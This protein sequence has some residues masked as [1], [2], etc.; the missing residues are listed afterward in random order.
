LRESSISV[1]DLRHNFAVFLLPLLA[2]C[3]APSGPIGQPTA[4]AP[5]APAELAE[6][7]FSVGLNRIAEVYVRPVAVGEL[8]VNGLGN[9]KALDKRLAVAR[10]G[11]RV[12]FSADGAELADIAAPATDDPR[13]WASFA[14]AAVSRLRQASPD[15]AKASDDDI[16]QT[17][18]DGVTA[19]L[20]DYSRYAAPSRAA[21]ERADREGYGGIG[22]QIEQKDGRVVIVKVNGD[23]PAERAGLKSGETLFRIDGRPTAEMDQTAV[24]NALRGDPN[25]VVVLAVGP[26]EA[27]M[28]DVEVRREKVVPNTVEATAEGPAG[29][30]KLDRFNVTSTHKMRSAVAKLKQ[31][32]GRNLKGFVLDLRGNP[33]GLLDQAVAISDLFVAGGKIVLTKGRHPDSVNAYDADSE[34]I[35]KGL[36]LV[37][38]VDQ[39]SASAAE[40]VA[41]ALK[42]S[43][44]AVVIG[45]TSYG[46]GSVQTVTRLPND[47]E[48]F[49]TWSRFYGPAG[50]TLH[51]LGVQPTLCT[52]ATEGAERLIGDLKAGKLVP[53]V[54]PSNEAADDE[55]AV[56]EIRARCPA[57][58][59]SVDFDLAVAKGLIA[60]RAL[61]DRALAL[62]GIKV[63]ANTP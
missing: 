18:F 43:G 31:E 32:M 28:R 15:L 48:L 39:R 33:G 53:P 40:I 42:D 45:A 60:D 38:L 5:T 59:E 13:A 22:V 56:Q 12:K 27:A 17:V 26:S 36:P 58:K 29:V 24:R 4:S 41:A 46:K 61:Y 7:V 6:G 62:N 16:Y 35:A 3:A 37:V 8:T 57:R 34:D 14:A 25:T 2:A 1:K 63:A 11:D 50:E 20:D 44:R 21:L 10:E 55:K 9:L 52:T 54:Q 49:L 30:L 19:K 23:T 51:K 47:A